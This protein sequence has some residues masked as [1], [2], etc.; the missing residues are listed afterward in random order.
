MSY[1]RVVFWTLFPPV[2]CCV[3]VVGTVAAVCEWLLEQPHRLENW[4]YGDE[5]RAQGMHYKGGGV[6]S[7]I[8]NNPHSWD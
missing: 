1:K 3:F 8:P 7:S 5:R 4:A 6:W 2:V